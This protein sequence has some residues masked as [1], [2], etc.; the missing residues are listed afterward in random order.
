MTRTPRHDDDLE[1]RRSIH[2]L[3]DA[4]ERQAASEEAA[5]ARLEG[6]LRTRSRRSVVGTVALAV[7]FVAAIVVGVNALEGPQVGGPAAIPPVAGIFVTTEPDE[8]GSCHAIRLYGTTAEDGR[9]AL[10]TWSGAPDCTARR[11]DLF[12]GVGRAVGVRLPTGAG[13]RVRAAEDAPAPLD[14]LELVLEVGGEG[15]PSV[16]AFASV[17]AVVDGVGGIGLTEVEELEIPYRPS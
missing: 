3:G 15:E 17:Q 13:I 8:S 2:E 10:W 11:S 7:V 14:G 16:R 4:F 1:I 6:R 9:V 5:V 12:T